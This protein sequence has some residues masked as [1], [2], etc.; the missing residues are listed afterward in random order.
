MSP[1]FA[2]YLEFD[3]SQTMSLLENR[4]QEELQVGVDDPTVWEQM[5]LMMPGTTP[6]QLE[7]QFYAVLAEHSA[8]ILG[9]QQ[10]PTD[11][12]NMD[13][14]VQCQP[15]VAFPQHAPAAAPTLGLPAQPSLANL[16]ASLKQAL[17]DRSTTKG[18]TWTDE[19]HRL[20]L[21]GMDLHGKGDWKSISKYF[22]LSRT[23]SQIASHA[24]K[25]F[26]RKLNFH[27]RRRASIHDLASMSHFQNPF[28][29]FNNL[30]YDGRIGYL[31]QLQMSLL[32]DNP[33]M[34]AS[35]PALIQQFGYN[36]NYEQL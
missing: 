23:P 2:P 17:P 13:Y 30:F 33:Y 7:E 3:R 9:L 14:Q 11:Q 24:Q 18:A 32:G 20:F 27:D 31:G 29:Y 35:S 1:S 16:I 5:A 4:L 6:K 10:L 28:G 19:E 22:V 21:L 26:N 8:A 12:Q 36:M 15:T 25:F 34:A